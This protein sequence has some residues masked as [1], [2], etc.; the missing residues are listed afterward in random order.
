M[1]TF[2]STAGK[3][4]DDFIFDTVNN[5]GAT[6]EWH[7]IDI[8]FKD[9]EGTFFVTKDAIKIDNV[10]F[11]VSAELQQKIADILGCT[12]LTA[13]LADHIF[14]NAEV[15][16]KP[17][18]R[19]IDMSTKGMIEHSKE[20]DK[21]IKDKKG[22][23]ST[24]GKHWIIDDVLLKKSVGTACNYGWHFKGGMPG[25]KGELP[26]CYNDLPGVKLIQSRGT[27]HNL[28]HVDYAQ[29]CSLV[30]RECEVNGEKRD[31]LDIMQ[32]SQLS[33]LVSHSG[34]LKIMRQPGMPKSNITIIF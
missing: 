20:I 8:K 27:W 18:P 2:P 24:V 14:L 6:I 26:V 11:N 13:K 19:N 7:P 9:M 34:P 29:T 3:Q 10:R 1:V 30:A 15:I 22:L 5:N 32:H 16:V 12:L 23:V 4:R 31:I 17:K 28:S 21:E 33:Y 25:I